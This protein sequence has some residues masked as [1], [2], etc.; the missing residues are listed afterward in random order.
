M[1]ETLSITRCPTCGSGR[2]RKVR[3]DVRR[4]TRGQK[5]VVRGLEFHECP[6]CREK[7]FD[8]RAMRRIQAASPAYAQAGT[9]R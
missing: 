8:R 1:R 2:I 4:E 9:K 7:V 6:D 5:Y 3:R